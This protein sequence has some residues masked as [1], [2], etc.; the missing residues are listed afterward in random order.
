MVHGETGGRIDV[1]D[2]MRVGLDGGREFQGDF[3]ALGVEVRF[4]PVL[5]V[6][7]TD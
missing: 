2:G 6:I 7:A 4:P 5:E 1:A 3:A